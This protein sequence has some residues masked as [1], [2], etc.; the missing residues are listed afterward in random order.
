MHWTMMTL[1]APEPSCSL[2]Q[3]VC[4]SRIWPEGWK[5]QVAEGMKYCEWLPE[6]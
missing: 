1:K 6:S 2:L 3:K 4:P 5:A